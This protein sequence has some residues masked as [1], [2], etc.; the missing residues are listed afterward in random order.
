MT[1][2]FDLGQLPA[3]LKGFSLATLPHWTLMAGSGGDSDGDGLPDIYEDLVTR[4]D[5][6]NADTGNWGIDDGYKDLDADNWSNLQELSNGSNPLEWDQPAAPVNFQ[7]GTTSNGMTVL[8][9]THLGATLPTCFVIDR[10][11]R[12]LLS[13]QGQPLPGQPPARRRPYNMRAPQFETGPSVEFAR[14]PAKPS[15]S[16]F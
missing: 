8:T 12:R 2:H 14:V 10:A 6:F 3:G 4:T 7:A 16:G 15:Q 11:I 13:P 1:V 5:P 9:W